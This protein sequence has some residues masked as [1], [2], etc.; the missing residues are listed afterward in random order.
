MTTPKNNEYSAESIKVYKGLD[1]V[2][3]RPG[4]YI[5]NVNDKSGLHQMAYEVIDNSIDEILAGYATKVDVELHEDGSLSVKD[6]GRG[7]PIEIHK[8]ENMT[9]VEVIMTKLHAGGKFDSGTYKVSGGLHGVGVSV[10]NALSSWLEVYILRGDKKYFIRFE[11]G[12]VAS[13]LTQVPSNEKGTGTEVRFLPSKEI[14]TITE[15]EF[16]ILKDRLKELAFLNKGADITLKDR[17]DENNLLEENFKYDGGIKEYISYLNKNKSCIGSA[18]YFS[19]VLEDIEVE[20]ALQWNDTYYENIICFTNNIRQK[21]GGTHLFGFKSGLTKAFLSYIS[22][23]S[24][25]KKNDLAITGEDIREGLAAIVSVKMA[26]PTF[27]SQTKDKLVSEKA[28]MIVDKM[29]GQNLFTW[30]EKNLSLAKELIEKVKDAAGARIASKKAR[31]LS[32]K[33]KS[34]LEVS[35]LPGK[36]ADC[37]EK[38]PSKSEIFIVEGDSAGGTAKQGRNRKNQAILPIRGK[39]L[40]VEKARFDK[41]FS[42]EQ[43]KILIAGLGGGIGKDDFD[44]TKVRYHKI[45]IMTDADIDGAHIRT[46]LLTFFFRNMMQ[47]IESGYLYIAQPP[48]FF[49]S[50]AGSKGIYLKDEKEYQNYLI[51]FGAKHLRIGN[52]GEFVSSEQAHVLLNEINAF[53][54]AIRK[55]NLHPDIVEFLGLLIHKYNYKNNDIDKI[56]AFCAEFNEQTVYM[57]IKGQ[58]WSVRF[59]EDINS[60]IFAKIY[61]GILKEEKVNI[62]HLESGE[63][64]KLLNKFASIFEASPY[65]VK[66]AVVEAQNDILLFSC[67]LPLSLLT[68]ALDFAQSKLKKLQRFKGLGE[69]NA[70]QLKDTTLDPASRTL[71][72]VSIE[73]AVKADFIFSTLM[74]DAVEPRRDFIQQNALNAVNVDF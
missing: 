17:K 59:D 10:V 72:K 49:V 34:A 70:D 48:L 18:I 5:G 26:D 69:M 16:E 27:S 19:E 41:I 68:W 21:D 33:K 32:R 47:I 11:N 51:D 28:K 8:E 12:S 2:K 45:I 4:M 35:V 65:E 37:Q 57:D 31:D 43:I 71:L 56:H 42:S 39:I 66:S 3:K 54:Q 14:F 6:N 52:K 23:Y 53:L 24:L 67:P 1:A 22:A 64:F 60:L 55:F 44:I 63:I 13:P 25:L 50:F 62:K 61:S 30:L 74:G 36:L 7:I 9:A 20:I 73:D 58:N 40:N 15:F 38:D 46:L 29:I